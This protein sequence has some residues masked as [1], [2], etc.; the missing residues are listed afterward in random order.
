MVPSSTHAAHLLQELIRDTGWENKPKMLLEELELVRTDNW[1]DSCHPNTS[2][3]VCS[4]WEVLQVSSE[5]GGALPSAAA[6]GRGR[7]RTVGHV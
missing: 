1:L 4:S 6:S 5:P 2:A 3:D 7:N